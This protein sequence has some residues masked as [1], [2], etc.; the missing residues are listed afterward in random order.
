MNYIHESA[1]ASYRH[2]WEQQTRWVWWYEDHS[3]H[4]GYNREIQ[5]L[6]PHL[7]PPRVRRK[8]TRW[9]A[10]NRWIRPWDVSTSGESR[11]VQSGYA[12]KD[13]TKDQV[14]EDWRELKGFAR[15]K[16]KRHRKRS[17]PKWIK[18]QCNKDY[19]QF[20]RRELE[21]GRDERL[22]SKLRK[23]YFDPWMWD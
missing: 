2:W 10:G 6:Y 23:D 20:E 3:K 18:R 14:K 1:R 11:F 16:A 13:K 17:C 5:T 15:D 19:R 7:S 9:G 4:F 21:A 22:G 8:R 12:K